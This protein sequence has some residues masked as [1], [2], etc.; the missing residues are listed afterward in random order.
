MVD[1]KHQTPIQE[2]LKR[3]STSNQSSENDSAWMQGMLRVYGFPGAVVTCGIVYFEGHG[4]LEFPP[5]DIHTVAR[6]LIKILND[7]EGD[8][9]AVEETGR[10]TKS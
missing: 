8:H 5:T 6:M 9:N 3:L 1:Q 2:W 10:K 4:T 7:T